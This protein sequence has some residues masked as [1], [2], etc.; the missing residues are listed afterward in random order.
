MYVC[1]PPN[2]NWRMDFKSFWPIRCRLPIVIALKGEE[3][4]GRWPLDIQPAIIIISSSILLYTQINTNSLCAF[5][6]QCECDIG[7]RPSVVVGCCSVSFQFDRRIKRLIICRFFVK[8]SCKSKRTIKYDSQQLLTFLSFP[9]PFSEHICIILFLR[10]GLI[11]AIVV[12]VILV[13]ICL[14]SCCH[15]KFIYSQKSAAFLSI[16]YAELLCRLFS[17][18]RITLTRQ[19]IH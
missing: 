18:G 14:F 4:E 13:K 12:V 11:W 8:K 15:M 9:G 19:T 17:V 10:Y 16:H 5:V 7:L 2:D 6:T 1:I 3:C